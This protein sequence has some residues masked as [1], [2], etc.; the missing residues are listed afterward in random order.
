MKP[1]VEWLLSIA[2]LLLVVALIVALVVGFVRWFRPRNRY[3]GQET[4]S[5][6]FEFDLGTPDQSTLLKRRHVH[7]QK[8]RRYTAMSSIGEFCKISIRPISRTIDISHPDGRH[9]RSF[10]IRVVH[11]NVY[12]LSDPIGV[13]E[14]GVELP[15][16]G[17]VLGARDVLVIGLAEHTK[18]DDAIPTGEFNY[19]SI[20]D[21]RPR[22]GTANLSPSIPETGPNCKLMESGGTGGKMCLLVAHRL[23][24]GEAMGSLEFDGLSMSDERDHVRSGKDE[25]RIFFTPDDMVGIAMPNK[26]ACLLLLPPMLSSD[27]PF[28]TRATYLGVATIAGFGSFGIRLQACAS[29]GRVSVSRL[30]GDATLFSESIAPMDC[31]GGMFASK[32]LTIQAQFCDDWCILRSPAITLVAFLA[33]K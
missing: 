12:E 19:V 24:L 20:L 17:I 14:V 25:T 4:G 32:D 16:H 5:E 21:R 15:G 31:G 29:D 33:R 8:E 13:F 28:P 26:G 7:R 23:A 27:F 10:P 9:N 18:H 6:R 1:W 11:S 22:F 2:L 30:G 3:L